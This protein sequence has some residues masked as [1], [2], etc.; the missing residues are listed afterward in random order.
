MITVTRHPQGPRTTVFGYRTHHGLG[1]ILCMIAGV[2][3]R[4]PWLAVAGAAAVWHDRH[5]WPW[6]R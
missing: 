5:D 4:N 3:R 1:G 6:L 2:W